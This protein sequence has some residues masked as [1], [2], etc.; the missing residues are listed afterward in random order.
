MYKRRNKEFY[1]F[2]L[3][4]IGL[5]IEDLRLGLRSYLLGGCNIIDK[6]G[7]YSLS[8]EGVYSK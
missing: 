4:R 6:G 1:G 8:L 5:G 2:D 3:N 7:S